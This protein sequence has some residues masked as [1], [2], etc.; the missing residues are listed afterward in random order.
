[1]AIKRRRARK[2]KVESI[3]RSQ[4]ES[5]VASDLPPDILPRYETHKIKYL[6][7]HEYTP[8]W[9][10]DDTTFIEVKGYMRAN[11]RAKHLAI[12]KLHPELKIVFVFGDSRNKLNKASKTTYADWCNK[13]QFEYCDAKDLKTKIKD[14]VKQ[15]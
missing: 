5:R 11:D 7:E 3:Y 4:L 9:S 1:M 10:I 14:W 8:D 12:K 15:Q 6:V 13:Y 2:L